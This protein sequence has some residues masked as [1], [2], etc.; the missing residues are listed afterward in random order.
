MSSP[1][2]LMNC[3]IGQLYP[4]WTSWVCAR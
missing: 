1:A 2:D 3:R 4:L